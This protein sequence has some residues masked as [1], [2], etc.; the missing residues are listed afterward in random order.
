MAIDL[1][2]TSALTA[3]IA[4]FRGFNRMYTRFLGTLN[5]GLLDSEYSL[6][7]AR[8]LYEVATRTAPKASEIADGL[9]MDPGY[10]SR[11]LGKF[12]RDGLLERKASEQD[13]RYA[14][15]TLT[16]QGRSAFGRLNALS[17]EQA[18]TV[19]QELPDAV[20]GDLIG[21]MK[22][23]EDTLTKTE[24]GRSAYVLR[25][26]RAGD[27]G[28]VV[29]RE[30]VGYAEQYGWDATF[31]VL[32]ARIVSEFVTNFDPAR[33]RCWI[34]EVDGRSVGHIFLVKH[35]SGPDTA[36]LRLLFVEPSARGMGLGDALVKECIEFARAAGYRKVVLWTQSILTGAHRIY[37]KA[38]FRLVNEEP[39]HSFGKD[40]IGQEW[41]LE[42]V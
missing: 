13:G 14:D 27:M 21:C 16:E 40:L 10:L 31:E 26:H 30:G 25:P 39:H 8:V 33:E 6:A 12:E 38:G 17:E 4:T 28:W 9:G 15:L 5:E 24:R 42:L 3:D 7:E 41:E 37:R 2:P 35:P 19:L 1:I 34:A 29:H 22:T 32:V 20:R 18:R 11:L 23:I 36:K